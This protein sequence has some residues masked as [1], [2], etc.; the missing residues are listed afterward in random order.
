MPSVKK[1]KLLSRGSMEL[2]REMQSRGNIIISGFAST[3][4]LD[5]GRRFFDEAPRRDL[6]SWNSLLARYARRGDFGMVMKLFRDMLVDN[7][8]PDKVIAISL[9]FLLLQRLAN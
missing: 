4:Q 6:I 8:R 2:L 7:V 1:W 5:L 3:G 9:V